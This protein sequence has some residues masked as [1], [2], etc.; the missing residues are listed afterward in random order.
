ME[1]YTSILFNDAQSSINSLIETYKTGDNLELELRYAD[2][3]GHTNIG[4]FKDF[5]KR[6]DLKEIEY[7]D[8]S[9]FTYQSTIQVMNHVMTRYF[10]RLKLYENKKNLRRIFPTEEKKRNIKF[11]NALPIVI[12][13]AEERT[14]KGIDEGAQ[15]ISVQRRQRISYS[16]KKIPA[17]RVDVTIRLYASEYEGVQM[18][19]TRSRHDALTV[20]LTKDN[21]LNPVLYHAL[22]I[23]FEHVGAKDNV[24]KD[25]ISLF[26]Y[27]YEN[28]YKL[29][30]TDY[31]FI[32]TLSNV[33]KIPDVGIFTQ[34]L[35][36]STNVKEWWS[37]EKTDGEHR[38]LLLSDKFGYYMTRKELIAIPLRSSVGVLI[39]DCEFINDKYLAFDSPYLGKD[40]S[41]LTYP[42]RYALLKE[43]K[44][45]GID[46]K[47]AQPV[48]KYANEINFV[49]T[50]RTSP[51][52]G[53]MIDGIIIVRASA[54]Y[55]TVNS[56]KMK[57][58]YLNTIDF[59]V[60]NVEDK[61]YLVV[62]GKA[63]D[64]VNYIKLI[65]RSGR[66]YDKMYNKMPI[67][68]PA[69][70]QIEIIWSSP[71]YENMSTLCIDKKW[72]STGFFPQDIVAVNKLIGTK[73]D[74]KIVECAY[75]RSGWVP[76]HIRDDKI[77]PNNLRVAISNTDSIFNPVHVAESYFTHKMTDTGKEL[78][79]AF[80]TIN[81]IIRSFVSE[82]YIE[83]VM[84]SGVLLDIA[85]GR[86]ADISHYFLAG[87][88]NIF[89]IDSDASALVEYAKRARGVM[90]FMK[91]S[92]NYISRIIPNSKQHNMSTP[93]LFNA[94]HE[95]LDGTNYNILHQLL[96]RN[97]WKDCEVAVMNFAIHYLC[98]SY[99]SLV[100]LR[101]IVDKVLTPGG[102]FILTYYDGDE[103][104]KDMGSK[105]VL[106][107]GS[108]K[109]TRLDN[110]R[111]AM[112]RRIA[113][114]A[115]VIV[116]PEMEYI[117]SLWINTV[118]EEFIVDLDKLGCTHSEDIFNRWIISLVAQPNAKGL[119][120][121]FD[122]TVSNTKEMVDELVQASGVKVPAS[123]FD[124]KRFDKKPKMVKFSYKIDIQKE[125]TL[126]DP[127][128]T[129]TIS[130]E[131]YDKLRMMYGGPDDKFEDCLYVLTRRYY[132]TWGVT[133]YNLHA[134]ISQRA[135]Y[136][137]KQNFGVTIEC[138]A[139]PFNCLNDRYCS[140]FPDTD[141]VFGSLGNF[142]NHTF[143]PNDVLYLNPP[144]TESAMKQA[145]EVIS[146]LDNDAIVI[147]P[148]WRKPVSAYHNILD[149]CCQE[150]QLVSTGADF[151]TGS[152]GKTTSDNWKSNFV[153]EVYVKL[154]KDTNYTHMDMS[155]ILTD[156]V[157]TLSD[158]KS[159]SV[160]WASMPLPTIAS[161]GYRD[162][163]L[164]H[165]ELLKSVFGIKF[166]NISVHQP[167]GN[168]HVNDAIRMLQFASIEQT[169]DYCK[170]IRIMVLK[171]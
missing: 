88:R 29:F 10:P 86:G 54:P 85:G 111:G 157:G 15:L 132:T 145:A 55:Y 160:D 42:E 80:R 6:D 162:E 133:G 109:I 103:I 131:S 23:E 127:I 28:S 152:Q 83:P 150:K 117:R 139:S 101:M 170:Y 62:Q 76:M 30:N 104:L 60:K 87:V 8:E 128:G 32:K 51:T 53:N 67:N 36:E 166:K 77:Y 47:V 27:L 159:S 74:N 79:N 58:G 45:K 118:K 13:L 37:L 50:N 134:S 2:H 68:H 82:A 7:V 57:T 43:V 165:T 153:T 119:Q 156:F 18:K 12:S 130:L 141:G 147:V 48:T 149:K 116:K 39:I 56:F 129:M 46:I 161:S 5:L 71:F 20:K 102:V 21:V 41:Q 78:A 151:I 34:A 63:K 16:S 110:G 125:V 69:E 3:T 59:K 121:T 146:K 168:L 124:L 136:N 143:E 61:L 4:S 112:T 135:F 115:D 33:D 17:W 137:I 114:S 122:R 154:S 73:L 138:F 167:L 113:H 24:I 142:F 26:T 107:I 106:E 19:S 65:T 126:T 70:A 11:N 155:H 1:Q 94:I 144:F 72:D 49:N 123:F 52:T 38:V 95:M 98:D 120:L 163:P 9:I 35:L 22:D 89:A 84:T 25:M 75:S 171:R 90:Y 44:I 66:L 96:S 40:I 92:E 64:A 31:A 91:E 100:A 108:Y 158:S 105:G 14:V 164:V 140:A 81:H 169:I 93:M 148:S 97:E 99:A